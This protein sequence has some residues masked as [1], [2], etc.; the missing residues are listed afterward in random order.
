MLSFDA[1]T[2]LEY[3]V[4]ANCGMA[5]EGVA[6]VMLSQCGE[7]PPDPREV[8]M[9]FEALDCRFRCPLET[10]WGPE[11]G[12][13]G[14]PRTPCWLS[15]IDSLSDEPCLDEKPFEREFEDGREAEYCAGSK[16]SL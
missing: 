8:D 5:M 11:L 10:C 16:E 13:I 9:E 15:I 7:G 4:D 1:S 6:G 12:D 14:L 2:G 3:G